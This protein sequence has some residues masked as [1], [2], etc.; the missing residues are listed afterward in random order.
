MRCSCPNV[1]GIS[2]ISFSAASRISRLVHVDSSAGRSLIRLRARSSTRSFVSWPIDG[3]META[4]FPHASSS[5]SFASVPMTSGSSRSLFRSTR[6]FR[7]FALHP[8]TTASGRT[9]RLLWLSAI[10]VAFVQLPAALGSVDIL[11]SARSTDLARGPRSSAASGTTMSAIPLPP[12][13]PVL[14]HAAC[15]SLFACARALLDAPVSGA[16]RDRL[17]SDDGD[18]RELYHGSE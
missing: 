10:R 12:T 8:R 11:L 4:T 18:A 3:G 17:G 9:S 1:A 16:K 13:I 7:R 2:S 15:L 14:A 6:S 5:S